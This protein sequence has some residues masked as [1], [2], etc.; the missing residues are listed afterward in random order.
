MASASHAHAPPLVPGLRTGVWLSTKGMLCGH[1]GKVP[2]RRAGAGFGRRVSETEWTAAHPNPVVGAHRA[3]V[4]A[5]GH[6]QQWSAR[7]SADIAGAAAPRE[8]PSPRIELVLGLWQCDKKNH[9]WREGPS[10]TDSPQGCDP[11]RAFT[12]PGTFN[13]TEKKNTNLDP[14]SQTAFS[15]LAGI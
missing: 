4:S 2:R 14:V 5:A 9:G 13:S 15:G 12:L 11:W 6:G 10:L 7:R 1:I 8:A 3:P